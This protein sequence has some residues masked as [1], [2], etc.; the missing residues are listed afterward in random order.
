MSLVDAADA[1]HGV[2]LQTSKRWGEVK[3]VWARVKG[4]TFPS[5]AA[6]DKAHGEVID[7]VMDVILNYAGNYSNLILDPDLNSYWLMDM[8]L[9]KLPNLGNTVSK[10]ASRALIPTPPD[11]ATAATDKII[12]LAGLAKATDSTTVDLE[13]VNLVTSYKDDRERTKSDR[14]QQVLGGPLPD[15]QEPGGQPPRPAQAPVPAGRRRGQRRGRPP[16]GDR[17]DGHPE[18]ELRVL[19]GRSSPS[20]TTWPPPASS[21][22]TTTAPRGCSPRW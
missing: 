22:T 19:T 16:P 11:N 8:V 3:E 18:G 15:P 10:A 6:A 7:G 20:S 5:A 14:L 17:H 1:R 9:A 4:E 13:V 12:D 21:A 2:A